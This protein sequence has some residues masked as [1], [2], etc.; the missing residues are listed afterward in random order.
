MR[1]FLLAIFWFSNFGTAFWL[2]VMASASWI[3]FSG[4]YSFSELSLNVFLTQYVPW[5]L[6]L[7]TFIIALLGELGDLL[8]AIPVLV[9]APLKFVAGTIIGLWAYSAAK[10]IPV[11]PAYT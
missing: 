5:L 6:W 2:L 7:K 8:L 11:E 3:I 10:K 1:T 9:I 4:T